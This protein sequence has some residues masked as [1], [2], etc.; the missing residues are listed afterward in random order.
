MHV[1]VRKTE[2]LDQVEPKQTSC[3]LL[4]DLRKRCE[5]MISTSHPLSRV[6]DLLSQ[7]L[8]EVKLL[9]KDLKK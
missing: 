7:L 5:K 3:D 2:R 4:K 1:I 8:K 6:A 9:R